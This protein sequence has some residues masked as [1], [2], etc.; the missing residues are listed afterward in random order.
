MWTVI[1]L[2]T[3]I[4]A[5]LGLTGAGGSILALPALVTGL[6]WNVSQAAPTALVAVMAAAS[7]GMAEGLH[8]G[9]VRY[10]A[11]AVISA[12]GILL[13]P[14]GIVVA[15]HIPNALLLGLFALLAWFVAAR[16]VIMSLSESVEDRGYNARCKMNPETGRLTWNLQTAAILILIGAMSG[17]LSGLLGVGGGFVIVPALRR[18]TDIAFP[19]IVASSLMVVAIVS[20]FGVLTAIASGNAQPLQIAAPFV[21]S[22]AL[23]MLAGRI[24]VHRISAR[25]IQWCFAF[26]LIAV[27][28]KLALSAI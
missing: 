8:R 7:I 24:L 5:I 22:A 23:G 3:C 15:K 6:G 12:G 17:F 18:T 21:C 13:T 20:G 11:A 26:L 14:L 19:S 16:M 1:L 4:G 27:G 25:A 9:V 2:G 10:R 28:V